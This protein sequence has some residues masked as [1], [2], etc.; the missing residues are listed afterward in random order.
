MS[1]HA[2]YCP[3]KYASTTLETMETRHGGEE[4]GGDVFMVIDMKLANWYEKALLR[5]REQQNTRTKAHCSSEIADNCMDSS[6]EP[7]GIQD[8]FDQSN[9]HQLITQASLER[10]KDAYIGLGTNI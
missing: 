1:L 5:V 6:E 9:L 8:I 7:L 4:E 3:M 10:N 2:P